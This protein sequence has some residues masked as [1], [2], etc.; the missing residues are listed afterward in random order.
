MVVSRDP[1]VGVACLGEGLDADRN[2]CI[3]DRKQ[4][5]RI[6]RKK[7][8][9]RIFCRNSGREEVGRIG[10]VSDLVSLIYWLLSDESNF[11]SGACIPITGGR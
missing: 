3:R 10:Q 6:A 8:L 11:I 5:G 9:Y 2:P 1:T 7:R 4:L